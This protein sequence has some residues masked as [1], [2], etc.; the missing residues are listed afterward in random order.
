[1][2][3]SFFEPLAFSYI[4]HGLIRDPTLKE[5]EIN[6]DSERFDIITRPVAS[7]PYKI[8]YALAHALEE[9][10]TLLSLYLENNMITAV[11]AKEIGKIL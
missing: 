7:R 1:M 9:N 5:Q 10:D 4:K 8:D 3:T 2:M 11:G 6:L